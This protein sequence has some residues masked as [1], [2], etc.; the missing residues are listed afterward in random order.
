MKNELSREL[1]EQLEGMRTYQSYGN[2]IEE[3]RNQLG[4][5][6]EEIQEL[7][8]S[9]EKEQ[10][11]VSR[12]EKGGLVSFYLKMRKKYEETMDKEVLEAAAA[13]AK[14]EDKKFEEQ[15]LQ[16][17]IAGLES[18]KARFAGCEARYQELYEQ[19]LNELLVGD[20]Q[21]KVA[22]LN[23][24]IRISEAEQN[25][26]ELQEAID[27]GNCVLE[28][29]EAVEES[30]EDAEGY[31]SWDIM[32]GGMMVD[33][34]KHSSLDDAK[35]QVDYVQSLMRNFRTELADVKMDLDIQINTDGFARF[36]DFFFDGLFADLSM[37]D[38][39]HEAQESVEESRDKVEEVIERLKKL[40]QEENDQIAEFQHEI[41]QIV[42]QA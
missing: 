20:N 40:F 21:E 29:I 26:K 12:L 24:R 41:D 6:E 42:N 9:F 18:E 16:R 3:F 15:D 32:G 25:K 5:L 10:K 30:L 11:D 27:A 34:M 8:K 39:I 13:K 4:Q 37:Q 22:I 7:N 1:N 36:A 23:Y 2:K 17:R 19:K 38:R 33:M 14:L 31:G 35:E 28:G